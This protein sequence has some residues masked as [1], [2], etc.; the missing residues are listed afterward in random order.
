MFCGSTFHLKLKQPLEKFL[1]TTL[2][3]TLQLK[4]HPRLWRRKRVVWRSRRD[5]EV[6]GTR[7]PKVPKTGDR[8]RGKSKD[9]VVGHPGTH[10]WPEIYGLG[11][12]VCSDHYLLYQWDDPSW[13]FT[14]LTAKSH[15]KILLRDG[16]LNFLEK[17]PGFS[18]RTTWNY[19]EL[20]RF[21]PEIS[22]QIHHFLY[23]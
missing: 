15:L 4:R 2:P 23:K 11:Q 6:T 5:D 17:G 13:K 3:P 10:A 14:N 18:K 16:T 7:N 21:K 22:W 1:E 12:W 19:R 8:F 20:F 9:R